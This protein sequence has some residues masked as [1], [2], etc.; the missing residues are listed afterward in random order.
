MYFVKQRHFF[1][2]TD[3][4]RVEVWIE[5]GKNNSNFRSIIFFSNE[6]NLDPTLFQFQKY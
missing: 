6:K 4:Y 2:K 5:D 3:K 1:P